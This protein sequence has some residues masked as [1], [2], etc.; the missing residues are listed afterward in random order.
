MIISVEEFKKHVTTDLADE[1]LE[2]KLQA[3]ESAI[4]K[5]TNNNFQ[6]RNKRVIVNIVNGN[7]ELDGYEYITEG[8]TIQISDSVYNNGVYTLSTD[9][10]LFDE[11]NVLVTKVEYP[12]DIKLGLIN[13]LDWEINKREKVGVASETISRHSV[14][15][16]NMDGDNSLIGYPKSLVGFLRPYIK[17]RF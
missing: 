17:A 8:D 3:L 2:M 1:V 12:L 9:M 5:Y 11:N 7:L 10:N 16:F 13:L 15:Y 4:R 14:T 6:N